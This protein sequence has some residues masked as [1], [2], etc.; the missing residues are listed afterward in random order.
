MPTRLVAFLACLVAA[1]D[2]SATRD[3]APVNS[4]AN[5]LST[6]RPIAPIRPLARQF[7]VRAN[8]TNVLSAF[9]TFESTDTES[10]RVLVSGGGEATETPRATIVDGPQEL[11]VLGLLPETD[12]KLALEVTGHGHTVRLPTTPYRTPPLP[13][14]LRNEAQARVVG[15]S[16]GGYTLTNF[17]GPDPSHQ[18]VFAF[19]D[20]GR[21]RWYRHLPGIGTFAEQLQ[22][23]N[24]AT[25]MGTTV[26][27]QK[28]YGYYLEFTPGGTDVGRHQ[29]PHPLF[30][31][32]HELLLTPAPGGGWT[33]HLFSYDFRSVDTTRIG[34]RPLTS[35]AGHQ[36][37]RYQPDGTIEVP[38]SSW[39]HVVL[40]DWVEEPAVDRTRPDGDLDH[41]NSLVLDVDGNYIVSWRN[42]AEVTK[43]DARSGAVIYR[44]GGRN[45]EF[46]ILNDPLYNN[47]GRGWAFCGQHTAE[48][49]PNG[50]LLLFDNGLRHRPQL[51]RAVEYRLNVAARTATM[52]WEFRH[53]PDLYTPYT[54]SVQRLPNGNTVVG[55]AFTGAVVEV[56]AAR[57]VLWEAALVIN[58]LSTVNYRMKRIQSLYGVGR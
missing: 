33:T 19:D 41:P 7:A 47:E 22:N 32:N 46:R 25:F 52:V 34:G 35:L 56:D 57:N 23:G 11:L 48:A 31:D 30:T 1:C 13:A 6:V 4:A 29:A 37:V 50:N 10:A 20:R 36:I 53:N 17:L 8:P 40:E 24:Y 42:L 55:F 44:F 14:F 5:V 21:F 43:I 27:Y 51:S 26:G 58:G 39:N 3:V 15:T 45:N 28:E 49:L 2:D 16:S 9:V 18:Y 38:W 54:G 12:Y